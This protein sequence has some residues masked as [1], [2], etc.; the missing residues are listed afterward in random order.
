MLVET[1]K[2]RAV[3]DDNSQICFMHLTPAVVFCQTHQT[4]LIGKKKKE[5]LV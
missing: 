4:I 1:M 3:H 2:W 5:N